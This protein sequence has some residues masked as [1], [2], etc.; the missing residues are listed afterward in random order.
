[1]ESDSHRYALVQGRQTGKWS[2]PKGHI[3]RYETSYE[4]VCREI[5]EE[6]GVTDLPQP[7]YGVSL[8]IGYYYYFKIGKEIGLITHDSDEVMDLGW[9]SIDDMMKMRLNIDASTFLQNSIVSSYYDSVDD[10]YSH[11]SV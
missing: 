2:F 11:Y 9:F 5:S 6:I 10:E 3:N 4:C 8:K 7:E 1:M